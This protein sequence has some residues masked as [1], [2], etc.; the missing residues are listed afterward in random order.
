MLCECVVMQLTQC[1]HFD[2]IN[3]NTVLITTAVWFLG[4]LNKWSFHQPPAS[5][6]WLRERLGEAVNQRD[7]FL[8][9]I[10]KLKQAVHANSADIHDSEK[11]DKTC[12]LSFSR[13]FPF[14]FCYTLKVICISTELLYPTLFKL[15]TGKSIHIEFGCPHQHSIGWKNG[16]WSLSHCFASLPPLLSSRLNIWLWHKLIFSSISCC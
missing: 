5:L 10:F 11:I 7:T 12:R 3:Y 6:F 1:W 15:N 8:Q 13:R 4:I 2:Y 14:L 16:C 9:K